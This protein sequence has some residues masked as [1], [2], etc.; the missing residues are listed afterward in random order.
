MHLAD[1]PA[2]HWRH[3]WQ[4]TAGQL[5]MATRLAGL[6]TAT[7]TPVDSSYR[8]DVGRL[9][10]HCQRLIAAGCDGICLLG[11]TGEGP[12]FS[13]AERMR[14]LD[15]ML[16]DGFPAEKLIVSASAASLGDS[17]ELARQATRA[18]AAGVL[19]MPP[20]F[21]RDG[22]ADEGIFR[23][24][25]TLIDQ[26]GE[27]GLRVLL[28]HIPGACGVPVRPPVIRRLI[29]RY[30]GILVGIKDSGGDW[31][32]TEE[33]LRRFSSLAVFTGS[34]IHIHL[35]LQHHGAGTICGLGNV[36]APL[37]RSMFDAP[38]ITERRKFIPLILRA[39]S[40]MS[41]AAF[42]ACLKSW[43]ATEA[44]DPAWSRTLPPMAQL[45]AVDAQYLAL[46]FIAF[47][48]ETDRLL[49]PFRAA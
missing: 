9:L 15:A 27:P 33:L 12:E 4:A 25:A 48:R 34:E 28:Y 21:F 5:I 3:H 26:I 18:N 45:N 49:A 37:L 8:C 35:A 1:R 10:A 7:L 41:R 31:A 2:L 19:L 46:D 43:I 39:D 38:N 40:I 36:I 24:Y 13:A 47:Q 14:M 11:T 23:F 32:Y 30:P 6:W 17:V 44:G 16:A 29:E 22:I 20:F 42:I